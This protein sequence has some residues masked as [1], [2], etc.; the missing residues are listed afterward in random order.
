[1][2]SKADQC[3]DD[4]VEKSDKELVKE[5]RDGN[6]RA[7]EMLIARHLPSVYNFVKRFVD[8]EQASDV[9]QE[10]FVRVWKHIK[11]YDENRS[12]KVWLFTIAKRLAI[13]FTRKRKHTPFSAF[14]NDESETFEVEDL[15][16]LPHELFRGKE[17]AEALET[18][19]K[20]LPEDRRAIVILHDSEELSFKDIAEIVDRPMNTVKSQY[21]RALLFLRKKID[22]GN[23]PKL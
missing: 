15:S 20:E 4:S 21:R 18:L 2:S 1:M 9:A 10:T 13:D 23:A 12:F 8:E 22:D 14:E 17:I 16:P 11:R 5:Y 3:Y 19:V 6:E 7:I